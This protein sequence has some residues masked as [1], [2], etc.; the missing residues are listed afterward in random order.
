ME[1]VM[2]DTGS[3]IVNDSLH[4]DEY[5]RIGRNSGSIEKGAGDLFGEI[6]HCLHIAK[7]QYLLIATQYQRLPGEIFHI[8]SKYFMT[9]DL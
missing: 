6:Q 8:Y 9:M 5:L 4:L 3:S 7:Y 2:L 1:S